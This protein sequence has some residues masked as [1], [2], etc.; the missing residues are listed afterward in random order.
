MWIAVFA[1]DKKQAGITFKYIVGLMRSVPALAA[2]IQGQTRESLSLRN[3]VVVEVISA[4][5]AAP[6]GRS[7]ARAII[8]EA[9]FLPQDESANPDAELLRAVRPALARVPGSLLAVVSSP[10]ARRGVLW[11]AWQKYHGQPDSDVVLV[12]AS[13]TQLNPM[14]DV[15]AVE[16]AYEEDEASARA[17]YG[18]EF[19]GDIESF[20][21]R[22]AI[23]AA[24]IPGRLELPPVRGSC[25]ARSLTSRAGV[26]RTRRRARSPTR[27]SARGV[28]SGCSMSCENRRPPF[29][30]EQTCDAFATLLK[31][32]GVSVATADRYVGQFPVEQLQKQGVSVWPSERAKSDIYKEFLPYVNS[33]QGELLDVRGARAARRARTSHSARRTGQHRSRTRRT[34]RRGECDVRGV[35]KGA[36]GRARGRNRSLRQRLR[37]VG[38]RGP[39]GA[40]AGAGVTGAARRGG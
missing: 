17:E 2:L 11:R 15:R 13:T 33:G 10:Y 16:T 40:C 26:A 9:A 19:R 12:Q 8:E 38:G 34:R 25:T 3:G 35:G 27:S 37:S 22:D 5:I 36:A 23:N 20:L 18:A 21:T 28:W 39:R 24:V 4:T 1:P 29:S 6:R 14:F 7:Y 31:V 30:P 32:Y